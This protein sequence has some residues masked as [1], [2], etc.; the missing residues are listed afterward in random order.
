MSFLGTPSLSTQ[1]R[2]SSVQHAGY[3]SYNIE[4][5]SQLQDDWFFWA[6]A[7]RPRKHGIIYV[8]RLRVFHL[9]AFVVWHD[10]HRHPLVAPLHAEQYREER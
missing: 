4:V 9:H 3:S 10:H 8:N 5:Y 7:S 1:P 6:F 2:S